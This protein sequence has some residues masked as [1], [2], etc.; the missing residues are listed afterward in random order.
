[1]EATLA[2]LLDHVPV[3]VRRRDG[4]I[5]HWTGGCRD[6]YGYTAEEARGRP[7]HELLKTTFPVSAAAVEQALA[8]RGEWR[9]R[10][11]QTC[12][13]GREIWT[14]AV[15]RLRQS[16]N[17]GGPIVL[18]QA[19]D[20]TDRVVLEEKSALLS[21]ELQHRVRNILAVVQALARMSFPDAP[22]EQRRKMEERIGALAE[23]NKL[24]QDAS[25]SKAD[26]RTVVREV[27]GSLGLGERIALDGPDVA[28]TSDDA[29]G[30][31]LAVHE[32][33]TNAIKYG[34]LTQPAGRIALSWTIDDGSPEAVRVRWKESGGPP[35]E[36]PS[37][38][39]FG[40]L[41]IRRAISGHARPPVEIRYE[42]DG[43]A[44]ELQLARAAD[45]EPNGVA[46]AV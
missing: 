8:A 25:W 37:A 18:E 35:V 38:T 39:G 41:L 14:E 42:Q 3:F 27:A 31:S 15:L 26:L 33:C 5:L 34:A 21:R 16:V 4:E 28:V 32:L 44:C 9:G 19:T 10:L 17:P 24:L 29:I 1:M 36:P 7:S 6:L 12:K 11:R 40:T 13:S 43:V 30:L 2:E 23:A 22:A 46:I 45:G 20:I